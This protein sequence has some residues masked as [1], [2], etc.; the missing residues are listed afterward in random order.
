MLEKCLSYKNAPNR[1]K[2]I[3]N[4]P[5]CSKSFFDPRM[6]KKHLLK[7]HTRHEIEFFLSK[8][9]NK[10]DA[11][12]LKLRVLWTGNYVTSPP[13][14]PPV[15][16]KIC[17][18]HVPPHPKCKLCQEI[19]GDCP[20]YPP[21]KFYTTAFVSTEIQD[22]EI[23]QEFR[24]SNFHFNLND[25]EQGVIIKCHSSEMTWKRFA[26]LKAMCQDGFQ[27]YLLGVSFYFSHK[28]N[29]SCLGK[30]VTLGHTWDEENELIVESDV[31]WI[32]MSRIVGRCRVYSC[33]REK[34]Y[35][36]K[37]HM[38]FDLDEESPQIKFCEYL[39]NG[40]HIVK[41]TLD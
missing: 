8:L 20:L 6:S 15:P 39:W 21:I 14:P 2:T 35:E 7:R 4:C 10:E 37:S 30:E 33:N 17:F 19:A 25:K 12:N 34:F 5:L 23:S 41:D 22:E 29:I 11:N 38:G 36:Q 24:Q 1:S 9:T 27:R 18:K 32:D 3:V 13:M 40:R 26:R 16:L 28:E 31:H